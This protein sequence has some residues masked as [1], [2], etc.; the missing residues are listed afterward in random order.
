MNYR[1]APL[2]YYQEL[3][4]KIDLPLI[5]QLAH[6]RDTLENAPD[7]RIKSA[8]SDNIAGKCIQSGEESDKH[9]AV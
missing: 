6:L 1:F 3:L 7:Q 2:R 5:T 9:I 8:I 4:A